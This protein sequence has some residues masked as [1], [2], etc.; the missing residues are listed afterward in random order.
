MA[1]R[2]QCAATFLICRCFFVF[3]ALFFF[4]CV[5]S[6][7]SMCVV[8]LMKVVFL[9]CRCFF[10]ICSAFLF[11]LCCEH[12]Q[13]VCCQIDESCF[14]NLQVF[15]FYLQRV[16]FLVVLWAFAACVLS[17]WGSCFLNLQV[18][19]L[20]WALSATVHSPHEG[21]IYSC[22]KRWLSKNTAEILLRRENWSLNE[23]HQDS[24]LNREDMQV[25]NSDFLTDTLCITFLFSHR[26]VRTKKLIFS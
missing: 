24:L 19:F 22:F 13:H 25:L 14:L 17:N 26:C 18:F 21:E 20:C 23:L 4:G 12:L 3:A 6:I 7:C 9:I 8:K 1:E 11:W 2:A 16:S 5:V 15:Y 10:S